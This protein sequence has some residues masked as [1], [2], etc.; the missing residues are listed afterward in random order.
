MSSQPPSEPI[1]L[2]LP[3]EFNNLPP[4]R[5]FPWQRQQLQANAPPPESGW[6]QFLRLTSLFLSLVAIILISWGA[7]TVWFGSKVRGEFDLQKAALS[8]K[9]NPSSEKVAAVLPPPEV[10]PPPQVEVPKVEVPKVAA[11]MASPPSVEAPVPVLTPEVFRFEPPPVP[12]SP[13][14]VPMPAMVPLASAE[15]ST[16]ALLE[17]DFNP[18]FLAREL[19]GDTPMIRNWKTLALLTVTILYVNKPVVLAQTNEGDTKAIMEK[20]D[21]MDKALGEALGA[22]GQDISKIKK[23][24]D[25]LKA[26]A[27]GQNIGLDKANLKMG[28]LESQVKILL[29]EMDALK[30]R[31]PVEPT[32]TSS[33]DKVTLDDIRNRLGLIEKTLST[34]QTSSANRIALSPPSQGRV[35]LMNFYPEE[36]LFI[37]NQKPHRVAP[38]ATVP[39]DAIPAGTLQYEVISPTW[40]QRARSQTTLSPNE[41]FTL[42]AR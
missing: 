5:S 33:L 40:G 13:V 35:V 1:N 11:P 21:K 16:P 27:V 20:L 17:Q 42:T 30:K 4:E 9:L 37:V 22:I 26:D 32:T 8:P 41:T 3:V 28:S 36:L 29:A 25:N 23:D 34:M 6:S 14:P 39:L 12:A 19:R 18:P 38:N 31:T 7:S 15:S 10:Q 24:I 2:D